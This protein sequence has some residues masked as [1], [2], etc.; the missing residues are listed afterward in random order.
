MCLF[1]FLQDI[2]QVKT[3]EE[4]ENFMLKHGENIIDT[5]GAEVDR[6]EKELKVIK[7]SKSDKFCPIPRYNIPHCFPFLDDFLIFIYSKRPAQQ[8][9]AG[10][11]ET[12]L[13]VT[14]FCSSPATKPRGSSCGSGDTI[15]P[16]IAQLREHHKKHLQEENVKGPSLPLQ[17]SSH[18][19]HGKTP[20][21]N[22]SLTVEQ[23]TTI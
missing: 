17:S 7:F 2:Q 23:S 8:S 4:L 6:L 10:H 15:V 5:L 16:A 14:R 22:P 3:P 11:C 1:L 18:P 21:H 9:I 12:D 13:K 19:D 20:L